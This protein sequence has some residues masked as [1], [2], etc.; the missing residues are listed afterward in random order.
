MHTTY[1]TDFDCI[2]EHMLEHNMD[3]AV[4]LTDGY[5]SM[6]PG[7]TERLKKR[8]CVCS[9]SCSAARR[10]ARNSSPSATYSNSKT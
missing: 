1:G 7:I 5:A 8:G 2:A 3:K 6:S 9:P 4:I 10:S